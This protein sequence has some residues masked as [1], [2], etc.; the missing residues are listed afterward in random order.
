MRPIQLPLPD[1]GPGLTSRPATPIT[2]ERFRSIDASHKLLDE[3]VRRAEAENVSAPDRDLALKAV[4]IRR[5]RLERIGG[6]R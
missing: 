4:A 2:R 3:I 1:P 5:R 6:P